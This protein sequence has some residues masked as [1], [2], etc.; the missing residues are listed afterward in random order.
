[1]ADARTC[2]EE[3]IFKWGLEMMHG[4][5]VPKNIQLMESKDFFFL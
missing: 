2:E 1:M 4:N 3:A 5:T